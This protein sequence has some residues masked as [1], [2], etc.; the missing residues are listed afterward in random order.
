M[1]KKDY[2]LDLKFELTR[3]C[4]NIKVVLTHNCIAGN[5]TSHVHAVLLF[6][7]PNV[8][9]CAFLV[10]NRGQKFAPWRQR[11]SVF[12]ASTERHS[13]SSKDTSVHWPC[14]NEWNVG[15]CLPWSPYDL[16][17]LFCRPV[18]QLCG[19]KALWD[20][21]DFAEG[22]NNWGESCDVNKHCS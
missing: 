10:W 8:Q 12:L 4:S 19:R 13:R 20:G 3:L 18:W 1:I 6:N 22:V 15:G 5:W 11:Q 14:W 17:S 9:Y 7:L 21:G 16:C 2:G